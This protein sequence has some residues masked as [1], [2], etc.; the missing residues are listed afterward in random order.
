MVKDEHRADVM[1]EK[2]ESVKGIIIEKGSRASKAWFSLDYPAAV[3]TRSIR[4][5]ATRK[6][7]QKAWM[8][9]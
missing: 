4:S 6:L 1:K 9:I 2:W 8:S 5:R 3:A 7:V